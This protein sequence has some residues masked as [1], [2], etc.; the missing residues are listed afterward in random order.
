[1]QHFRHILIGAFLLVIPAY[2]SA[3]VPEKWDFPEKYAPAVAFL[4]DSLEDLHD[5]KI[6]W[7]EKKIGTTMAMRPTFFSF[8]K[9]PGKRTYVLIVNKQEEF[10]GV[11]LQ[12]V[13]EEAQVGVLAHELMHVRDYESRH[14]GGLVKRGWQYL[15]KRGKKRFEHEIDQMTIDAGFGFFLYHWSTYVLDDS[16]AGREYRRFKRKVYMRPD[17]II[18]E[19]DRRG[20]IEVM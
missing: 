16:D 18:S 15:S 3:Q 4:A 17:S 2:A 1:M 7:K 20:V 14:F 13:P 5:V 11:L 10:D 19:L 9:K 8:L 12:N 6:K